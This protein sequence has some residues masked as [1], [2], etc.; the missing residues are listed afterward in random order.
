MTDFA[1]DQHQRWEPAAADAGI[2]VTL[3]GWLPSA[4]CCGWAMVVEIQMLP[5]WGKLAANNNTKATRCPRCKSVYFGFTAIWR[6]TF[7][8]TDERHTSHPNREQ[9]CVPLI[10]WIASLGHS[11]MFYSEYFLP[12]PGNTDGPAIHK[13]QVFVG[14]DKRIRIYFFRVF[15]TVNI[16]TK[17]RDNLNVM[18]IQ[19]SE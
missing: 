7:K 18:R 5:M 6:P 2:A 8:I 3:N 13:A 1:N 17:V 10:R 15:R 11:I 14:C 9:M 4:E 12:P 19:G 16:H